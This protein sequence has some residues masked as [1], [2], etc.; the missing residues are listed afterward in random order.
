MFWKNTIIYDYC[1]LPNLDLIFCI[2]K[3]ILFSNFF[4][5]NNEDT[6]DN[7]ANYSNSVE[8]WIYFT[9]TIVKPIIF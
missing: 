5:F 6:F 9:K 7:D 3:N 4:D 8:K 2:A 1:F